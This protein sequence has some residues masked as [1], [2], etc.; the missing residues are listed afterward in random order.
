MDGINEIEQSEMKLMEFNFDWRLVDSC[1]NNAPAIQLS[2]FLFFSSLSNEKK[3]EIKK[4]LTA[5]GAAAQPNFFLQSINTN[6]QI[7]LVCGLM[8]RRRAG[9]NQ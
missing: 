3:E 1:D 8:K 9:M 7:S 2:L 6:Q 4:E 5:I